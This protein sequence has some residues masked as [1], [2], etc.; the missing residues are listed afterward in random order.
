MRATHCGHR[1]VG[2]STMLRPPTAPFSLTLLRMLWMLV[3]PRGIDATL[4]GTCHAPLTVPNASTMC[5]GAVNYSFFVPAG[6]TAGLIRRSSCSLLQLS[7][8]TR[9][10]VTASVGVDRPPPPP[11]P[12]SARRRRPG[13][14]RGRVLVRSGRCSHCTAADVVQG[15]SQTARV[16]AVPPCVRRVP[17]KRVMRFRCPPVPLALRRRDGVGR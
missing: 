17:R 5:A 8:R 1:H 11:T 3:R 16:R 4:A 14:A 10:R 6:F 13:P 7:P 2:A 12:S 9:R 15:C